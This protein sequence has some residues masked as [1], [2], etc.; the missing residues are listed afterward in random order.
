M[1][2]IA[3][4]FPLLA[5]LL[6]A[7]CNPIRLE[8]YYPSRAD[9]ER[10]RAASDRRE[11]P[12][13][14]FWLTLVILLPS[15]GLVGYLQYW[16]FGLQSSPSTGSVF[17]YRAVDNFAWGLLVGVFVG[18][19]VVAIGVSHWALR[20]GRDYVRDWLLHTWQGVH[21]YTNVRLYKPTVIGVG[22]GL[23]VLNF[24]VSNIYLAVDDLDV[25]YSTLT[26]PGSEARSIDAVDCINLYARRIAPIGSEKNR[27][28]LEIVFR[29]G[30]ALDTFYLIERAHFRAVVD[31]IRAA[32]GTT[33]PVNRRDFAKRRGEPG[34][35]ARP[36]G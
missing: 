20:Q 36:A 31:A 30:T 19:C 6:L 11:V 15:A 7:R 26:M 18:I 17:L 21:V 23:A 32:R 35:C 8:D 5:C 24:L 12:A 4:L 33:V 3:C 10:R 1:N 34:N 9:W 2:L 27:S 29:D 16:L 28:T 14:Y 22:I 25:R 13:V